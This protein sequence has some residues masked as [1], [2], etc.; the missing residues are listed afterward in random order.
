[1]AKGHAGRS[2]VASEVKI[3]ITVETSWV[4]TGCTMH[5]GARMAVVDQRWSFACLY[6]ADFGPKTLLGK[7][8]A[9]FVHLGRC[10]RESFKVA[11]ILTQLVAASCAESRAEARAAK[12]TVAS[13]ALLQNFGNC[14]LGILGMRLLSRAVCSRA[15]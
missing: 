10:Q 14:I 9:S 15:D 13:N 11:G 12:V 2:E 6:E 7:K 3:L 8:E 5:F 4:L 1:M